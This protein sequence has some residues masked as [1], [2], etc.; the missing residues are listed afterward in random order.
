MGHRFQQIS[1]NL[2]KFNPL[3]PDTMLS[4]TYYLLWWKLDGLLFY[5]MSCICE[6]LNTSITYALYSFC[7]TLTNIQAVKDQRNSPAYVTG[8]CITT[9]LNLIEDQE[10]VAEISFKL[11]LA[12]FLFSF[13]TLEGHRPKANKN[14]FK[15]SRLSRNPVQRIL[16]KINERKNS[17]LTY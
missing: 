8:D 12:Q 17:N 7:W 10:K 13:F 11:I 1:Y 2:A 16:G 6:C 5:I 4:S 9:Q 14:R 15:K 3:Y